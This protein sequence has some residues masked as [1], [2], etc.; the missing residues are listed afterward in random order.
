MGGAGAQKACKEKS[1]EEL[2]KMRG[3]KYCARVHNR[4]WAPGTLTSWRWLWDA[5]FF[6]GHGLCL[7]EF[8]GVGQGAL[9]ERREGYDAK[10]EASSQNRTKKWRWSTCR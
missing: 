1:E 4:V 9:A 6:C 5:G 3:K 10:P 8:S 2:G 7:K